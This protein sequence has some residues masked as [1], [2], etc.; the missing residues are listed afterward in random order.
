V[1]GQ[2]GYDG[3]HDA[4]TLLKIDCELSSLGH[5]QTLYHIHI[6]LPLPVSS[7]ISITDL[8]IEVKKSNAL[9]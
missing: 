6:R 1:L 7:V 2:L 9:L 8:G 5:T 4:L 3:L